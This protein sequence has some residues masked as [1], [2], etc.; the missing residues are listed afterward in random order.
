MIGNHG[1]ENVLGVANSSVVNSGGLQTVTGGITNRTIVNSGGVELV[2]SGIANGTIIAGGL[3]QVAV[4]GAAVDVTFQGPGGK[5]Q[6]D[7]SNLFSGEISGF[8]DTDVIDLRDIA[9]GSGTMLGYAADAGNTS[10]TLTLGDGINSVSLV[11]LGQYS[12][13]NFVLSSDGHGGTMITE[14]AVVPSASLAPSPLA[15]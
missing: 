7:N 14:H 8:G 11:L 12:A 15:A 6:L 3:E 9:F 13:A 1:K 5:L 2:N 4:G 10:G